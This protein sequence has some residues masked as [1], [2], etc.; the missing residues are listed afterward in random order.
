MQ[1]LDMGNELSCARDPVR[2]LLDIY[3]SE[4][5]IQSELRKQGERL[6]RKSHFF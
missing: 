1:L 4:P 5:E 6:C 2:T 3:L